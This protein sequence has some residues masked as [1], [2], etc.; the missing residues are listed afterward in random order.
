MLT[1]IFGFHGKSELGAVINSSSL[2][3]LSCM[4]GRRTGGSGVGEG[5]NTRILFAFCMSGGGFPTN[6]RLFVAGFVSF[7]AW[8]ADAVV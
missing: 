8:A 1:L 6:S 7:G 3:S 2:A 4:R 5:V